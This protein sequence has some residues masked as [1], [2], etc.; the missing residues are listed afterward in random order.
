MEIFEGSAAVKSLALAR[1]LEVGEFVGWIVNV[2]IP[3]FL[4]VLFPYIEGARALTFLSLSI[5]QGLML[6][7]Q[8]SYSGKI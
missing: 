8:K 6:G 4:S 7:S 2:S 3:F 5:Q 1:V